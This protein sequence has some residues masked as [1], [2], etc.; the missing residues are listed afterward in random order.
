MELLNA[1]SLSTERLQSMLLPH[2]QGWKCDRLVTYVRWSRGA[3]FSGSCVY[4]RR[5]INVNLGKQ[6][7]YP[8]LMDTHAAKPRYNRTHWWRPVCQIE[9][10]DAYQLVLFV[11]LHE[12]YHWLIKQ[13][14]RNMRQKEGRCDRFAARALVDWH[15]CRM[16][17]ERGREVAREQWDFQDLESFVQAARSRRGRRRLEPPLPSGIPTAAPSVLRGQGLLFPIHR[18]NP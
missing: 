13:A 8:Y 7:T 2:V 4:D 18:K 6:N 3:E 1:T 15:G 17:D 14:R 11:F 16:L 12:L 5:Q 9:L 10:R